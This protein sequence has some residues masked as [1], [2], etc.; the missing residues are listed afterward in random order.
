MNAKLVYLRSRSTSYTF[1][2]DISQIL[3]SAETDGQTRGQT[4]HGSN[5]WRHKKKAVH[6]MMKILQFLLKYM[7]SGMPS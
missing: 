4:Q 7:P 5:L 1:N 3:K 6:I 2:I